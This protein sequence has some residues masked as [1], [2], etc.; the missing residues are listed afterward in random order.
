VGCV[1]EIEQCQEILGGL[2]SVRVDLSEEVG[3]ISMIL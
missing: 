2:S 1:L 3:R